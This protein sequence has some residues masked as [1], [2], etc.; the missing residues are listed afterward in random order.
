MPSQN[1]EGHAIWGPWPSHLP[2]RVFSSYTML[3]GAIDPKAIAKT[4]E[5]RGFPAIAITDR[6]GLY[7]SAAF[8]KACKDAGVQ[9][10]VGTML[11]VARPQREGASAPGS[12][13]RRRRSTGWR[14]MRR[15][16]AAMT[17]SATSSAAPTSIARSNMRRMSCCRPGRPYRWPDLP[18]GCRARALVRL[19]AGE[20]QSAAESYLTLE[21]LFPDRLYLELARR[22][23]AAEEAAEDALIALAYAR[24]LPLVATNPACFADAG[25]YD[26]HDAMLCIASS[27]HVD[28]TG[29][30]ALLAAMVGQADGGMAE[31]FAD[32]P[33]ALANTLVV[34][35]RTACIPPKR[36]PIL[37]SLAGDKEGEA[38]PARRTGLVARLRPYYPKACHGELAHVL[39][40]GPSRAARPSSPN[41]SRPAP[42][43]KCSTIASASNS[44]SRSSTAWALA[45]TS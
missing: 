5:K 1:R 3:D 38:R 20:Q 18:D 14:S 41:W 27:T 37:P 21:A 32:V 36:K 11:A 28:S 17:I 4:A 34:A 43:T 30:P 33:E 24:D 8:A 44:R 40:L 35:Q 26:A 15:T 23:E 6:N 2:L 10:M 13:R 42:G 19:L 7:G 22:G 39:C 29:S 31:L 25:F 9:P 45:A 16:S 12:A